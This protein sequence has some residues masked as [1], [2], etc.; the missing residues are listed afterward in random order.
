[1]TKCL[2]KSLVLNVNEG[3]FAEDGMEWFKTQTPSS[4]SQWGRRLV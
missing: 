3:G 2:A 1:M 4:G